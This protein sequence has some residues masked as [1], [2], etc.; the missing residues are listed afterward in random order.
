VEQLRLKLALSVLGSRK[1]VG[2]FRQS[3]VSLC[4]DD[5]KNH[6]FRQ[7]EKKVP[8]DFTNDK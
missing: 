2:S 8:I 6:A 1:L 4:G 3:K 5:T 7:K